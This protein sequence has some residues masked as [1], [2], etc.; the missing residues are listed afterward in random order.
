MYY[1][2]IFT[3]LPNAITCNLNLYLRSR[4][5]MFLDHINFTRLDVTSHIF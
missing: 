5:V 2:D 4:M 1:S 3:K